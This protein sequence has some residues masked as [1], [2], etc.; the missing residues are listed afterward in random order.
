M[1]TI[2]KTPFLHC[3]VQIIPNKND[4]HLGKLQTSFNNR[5][6]QLRCNGY[7]RE[8]SVHRESQKLE[9]YMDYFTMLNK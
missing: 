1:F 4:N 8:S 5:F 7:I 9:L 6:S 3:I 2:I